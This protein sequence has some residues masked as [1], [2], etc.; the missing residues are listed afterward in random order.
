MLRWLRQLSPRS[1]VIPLMLLPY[2]IF[3][4]FSLF[5]LRDD[6]I[7]HVFSIS[8]HLYISSSLNGMLHSAVALSAQLFFLQY[9][10]KNG[11]CGIRDEAS[12]VGMSQAKP[13]EGW[14]TRIPRKIRRCRF[15]VFHFL[16][17]FSRT[18]HIHSFETL[19]V[20][21]EFFWEE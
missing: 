3:P 6:S 16:F 5:F 7:L 13:T 9:I 1:L 17:I 15:H 8:L 12:D 21:I 4:P 18:F 2:Q 19:W 10:P 20:T 14:H 11:A